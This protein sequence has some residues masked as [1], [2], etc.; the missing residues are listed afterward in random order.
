MNRLL[1]VA[2]LAFAIAP[3]SAQT[4]QVGGIV[5]D[6][7]VQG[8]GGAPIVARGPMNIYDHVTGKRVTSPPTN[9]A[10]KTGGAPRPYG[11]GMYKSSIYD[12]E[13]RRALETDANRIPSD[14]RKLRITSVFG[15]VEPVGFHNLVEAERSLVIRKLYESK[16]DSAAKAKR[17]SK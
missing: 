15:S 2:S 6:G 8:R 11:L 7:R 17:K 9:P 16:V 14:Q 1:I 10:P 5:I 3:L 12:D 4:A 13:L